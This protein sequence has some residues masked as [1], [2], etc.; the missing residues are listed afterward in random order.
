M[1]LAFQWERQY[2]YVCVVCVYRYDCVYAYIHIGFGAL[3]IWAFMHKGS[4]E[5]LDKGLQEEARGASGGRRAEGS[6]KCWW[7]PSLW[8]TGKLS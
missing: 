7:N 8:A 6:A 3:S 1:E 2:V 4:W 5:R